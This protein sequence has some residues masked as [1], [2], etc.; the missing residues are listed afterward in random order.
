MLGGLGPVTIRT[1]F[2]AV[3]CLSFASWRRLFPCYIPLSLCF[4]MEQRAEWP[5]WIYPFVSPS[6]ECGLLY[7]LFPVISSPLFS[8]TRVLI[9]MAGLVLAHQGLRGW[10][11]FFLHPPYDDWTLTCSYFFLLPSPPILEFF[12]RFFVGPPTQDRAYCVSYFS[13]R[14]RFISISH[15][16]LPLLQV[17]PPSC[18]S[19]FPCSCGPSPSWRFKGRL[20][21]PFSPG[22][23]CLHGPSFFLANVFSRFIQ[24]RSWLGCCFSTHSFVVIEATSFFR[25]FLGDNP[26]VRSDLEIWSGGNSFFSDRIFPPPLFPT[27]ILE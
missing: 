11:H 21:P 20:P 9:R 12:Q 23:W 7:L 26:A 22:L 2:C 8:R 1:A 5:C 24:I 25:V 10:R 18:R 3:L 17:V 27:F 4:P 14:F 13:L 15:L 16:F 6:L 19:S